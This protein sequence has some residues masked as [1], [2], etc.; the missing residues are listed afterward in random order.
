M[1]IH[2][3]KNRLKIYLEFALHLFLHRNTSAKAIPITSDVYNS[4]PLTPYPFHLET[5]IQV[6]ME[7]LRDE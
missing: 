5:I 4:Y 3:Y 6:G 2:A 1:K 7:V